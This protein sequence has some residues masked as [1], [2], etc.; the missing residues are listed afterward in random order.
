MLYLYA[1]LSISILVSLRLGYYML[2]RLD[3][4]DWR[5]DG[6]D[7]WFM[8]FFGLLFWPVLLRKPEQLI[9]PDALFRVSFSHANTHRE[10]DRLWNAPPPCAS[11]IRFYEG[12]GMYEEA[13]GCFEFDAAEVEAA[14]REALHEAPHLQND[15]EGALLRWVARRDETTIE[16]TDVPT[17]WGRFQYIADSLIRSGKVKCVYCSACEREIGVDQ[18]AYEDDRYRPGWN[19]NRIICPDGHPLLVVETIHLHMAR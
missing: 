8:F 13:E 5:Y 18:L 3:E 15:D 16:P 14:L 17:A 2:T 12:V 1:Y 10:R 4:Y 7:H 9:T 19:Y 6:F 11:V